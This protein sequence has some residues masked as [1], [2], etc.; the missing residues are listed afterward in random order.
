[1][2]T[3]SFDMTTSVLQPDVVV[4]DIILHL[5]FLESMTHPWWVEQVLCPQHELWQV[6]F[7]LTTR[8]RRVKQAQRKGS[9]KR[10]Q[11]L[12]AARSRAQPQSVTLSHATA[13]MP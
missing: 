3:V 4:D 12:A 9:E 7:R 8:E 11:L 2:Q 1:M 10:R 5:C 6:R 13:S